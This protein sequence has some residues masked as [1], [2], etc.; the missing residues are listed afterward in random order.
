M[1]EKEIRS[2]IDRVFR[3]KAEISGSEVDPLYTNA[4]NTGH[5]YEAI[6]ISFLVY[7]QRQMRK[8]PDAASAL[9]LLKETIELALIKTNQP[10]EGTAY[11]ETQTK[12]A[13]TKGPF[14]SFCCKSE[15]EVKK[16]FSGYDNVFICSECV[17]ICVGHLKP[18]DASGLISRRIKSKRKAKP[19]IRRK[20]KRV[21]SKS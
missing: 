20:N 9:Y 8:D 3:D 21:E 18:N 5:Y 10:L 14:C 6:V 15:N 1:K 11:K 2:L 16:L 17:A 19:K 4:V 12:R 13:A 7:C